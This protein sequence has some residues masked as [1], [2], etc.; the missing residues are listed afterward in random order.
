MRILFWKKDRT[1]PAYSEKRIDLFKVYWDKKTHEWVQTEKGRRWGLHHPV[2]GRI[3][4]LK[5]DPSHY[6]KVME[7]PDISVKVALG[8]P[9]LGVV[10]E[11][12]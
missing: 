1:R 4:A 6:G 11:E 2:D 8:T 9:S 3:I 7:M 10:D 12:E 5:K